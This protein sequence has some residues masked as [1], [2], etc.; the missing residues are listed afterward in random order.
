MLEKIL[1]TLAIFL[2][3]S[4]AHILIFHFIEIE[5]KA[6]TIE[7]IFAI[8]FIIMIVLIIIL[9]SNFIFKEINY[10]KSLKIV[11]F[12]NC[13]I[14]YLLLFFAYF[15]IYF[16]IDRSISIRTVIELD[17]N[18]QIGMTEK[19]LYQYYN[20]DMIME[21]RL[22]HLVYGKFIQLDNDKYINTK[23]GIIF[24]KTFNFLK[25]FLNLSEG[26]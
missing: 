22:N 16:I 6:E 2:L 14:L 1:I 8:S 26:G 13:I 9:P 5:F 23:K 17:K 4:V 10:S 15:S 3:A 18:H 24:A 11:I 12:I 19:E 21:R 7:I 25:K 20:G